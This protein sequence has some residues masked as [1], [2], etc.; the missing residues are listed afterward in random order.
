MLRSPLA[1]TLALLCATA[2]GLFAQAGQ[3]AAGAAVAPQTVEARTAGMTKIPGYF[4]LY[5]DART[6]NLYLEINHFNADF[7]YST[8]LAAGLG[9]NDLGLDRGQGGQGKLVQFQRVGPKVLLVQPNQS[10]R[11]SSPNEA[12]RRS[13]ADSFAKSILWGFT[14][15][16]QSNGAVLVDATDF[17]LRDGHGAAA[18]LRQIGR[19]HV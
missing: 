13:V 19:A 11:S 15:A 2:P 9:S 18:G 4:S 5:W 3:P 12:E 10:F 7:L 1:R 8:G 6:G 14:V 17:F 16:A